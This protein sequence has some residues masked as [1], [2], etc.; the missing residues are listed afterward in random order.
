MRAAIRA[1]THFCS[2][3]CEGKPVERQQIE[4]EAPWQNYVETH[5]NVMRR[6]ADQDYARATTWG[7]LR[8]AHDRFF[9]DYNHQA[10]LAHRQRADGRRSPAEVLGWVRD[11]WCEPA[12]LNRLFRLRSKRVF[13]RG[14][15][16]RFRG[17]S[18]Y[19]ERRLAGRRGAV[20]LSGDVLTVAYGEEALA[21]Y[22]VGYAAQTRRIAS[23]TDARLFATRHPSPQPFLGGL[24]NF[25]WHPALPLRPYAPRRPRG[26]SDAQPRLL[27]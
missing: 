2:G 16:V 10:H 1:S 17:S 8:A 20:W 3:W 22:R 26:T 25:A 23:G 7:E 19:G 14:G 13:D 4:S 12:E 27:P 24:G 18:V 15:Y 21:Q 6:M 5:F 11:A 9:A